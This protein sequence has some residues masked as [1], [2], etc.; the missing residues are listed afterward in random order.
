MVSP[1]SVVHV[2]DTKQAAVLASRGDRKGHKRALVLSGRERFRFSSRRCRS[3][4]RLRCSLPAVTPQSTVSVVIPTYNLAGWIGETLESVLAQSFTDWEAVVVDDG[5]T[6]ETEAV[7]RRY[8]PRIRYLHQSNAGVSAARNL[9][10]ERTS[11]RYVA[12]LDAD[13]IWPPRKLEAQVQLLESVPKAAMAYGS[14]CRYRDG[15]VLG[16]TF[17][18]HDGEVLTPL[19]LQ[20]V[21]IAH[22]LGAT[23]IRRS[24]LLEVGGLDRRFGISA[25]YDLWLRIAARYSVRYVPDTVL[26]YRVRA[27]AWHRHLEGFRSDFIAVLNTFF[28]DGPTSARVL[29]LRDR[30]YARAHCAIAGEAARQ[31]SWH[32]FVA[33]FLAAVRLDPRFAL[34]R[35]ALWPARS[36]RRMVHGDALGPSD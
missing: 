12:F 33:H 27:D 23:L 20:D 19:L 3:I 22:T 35:L 2:A 8:G 11:G 15:I 21:S 14:V 26:Y 31:G 17:P 36:L 13:D 32:L 9:G 10:V 4:A 28:G 7:V 6:D 16:C 34:G 18:V 24:V 30:V 5:S 25:D 29:P 1:R